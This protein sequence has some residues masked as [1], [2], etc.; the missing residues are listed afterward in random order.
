MEFIDK[1]ELKDVLSRLNLDNLVEKYEDESRYYHNFDHIVYCVNKLMEYNNIDILSDAQ[2]FQDHNFFI[3][4]LAIIFHDVE[5]DVHKPQGH[6]IRSVEY[7]ASYVSRNGN[8]LKDINM[9][10]YVGDIIEHIIS[11]EH[12]QNSRQTL[13]SDIDLLILAESPDVYDKYAEN[14]RRENQHLFSLTPESMSYEEAR[15]QFLLKMKDLALEKKVFLYF[16]DS[17]EQVIRNITRE[18][19]R[20]V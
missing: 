4:F 17:H 15:I 14:V 3:D 6:E 8:I 1:K 19:Y 9:F 7:F 12:R 2:Y 20:L 13:V 18:L 10:Q 5:Y 16:P 11:T